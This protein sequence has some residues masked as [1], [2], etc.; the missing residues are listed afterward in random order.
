MLAHSDLLDPLGDFNLLLVR[1][2]AKMV[3]VEMTV[4]CFLRGPPSRKKLMF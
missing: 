4:A 2:E 3:V 1:C